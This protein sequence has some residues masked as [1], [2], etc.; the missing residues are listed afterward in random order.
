DL[1][2][3]RFTGKLLEFTG[4]LPAG[5]LERVDL[6]KNYFY[7]PANQGILQAFADRLGNVTMTIGGNCF[8][9]P[10]FFRLSEIPNLIFS[11][12]Q[13]DPSTC[14]DAIVNIRI[15]DSI[16]TTTTSTRPTTS[17]AILQQST[18]TPLPKLTAIPIQ[19]PTKFTKPPI[20]PPRETLTEIWKQA[21]IPGP[22]ATTISP[23]PTTT[24]ASQTSELGGDVIIGKRTFALIMVSILVVAFCVG[25]GVAVVI[26]RMRAERKDVQ[27][28]EEAEE[29]E[30]N[31]AG[32]EEE[33]PTSPRSIVPVS[34][35]RRTD[36]GRTA[37]AFMDE[38]GVTFTSFMLYDGAQAAEPR[39]S[40][41]TDIKEEDQDADVKEHPEKRGL[42]DRIEMDE[43][44]EP[45]MGLEL[46]DVVGR[47]RGAPRP[48]DEK[49]GGLEDSGNVVAMP[50][51][52][53]TPQV[54]LNPDVDNDP[55]KPVH[56]WTPDEVWIWLDSV[57]FREDVC[58][59]FRDH[60]VDGQR[61]LGLTDRILKHEMKIEPQSLRN[62]ILSIRGKSFLEGRNLSSSFL[63]GASGDGGGGS[64][65]GTSAGGGGV[66]QAMKG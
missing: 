50:P 30:G 7:G 21:N 4:G 22:T 66:F 48:R 49:A 33:E 12:P 32:D 3:N 1:S 65:A 27:E 24:I 59:K 51:V 26:G 62:A 46:P 41:S 37:D 18:F 5:K 44:T 6:L 17:T 15:P 39:S 36:S 8:R 25:V 60:E 38:Q 43:E 28:G 58:K 53:E 64:S 13:E 31:V 42:V 61:W 19:D 57:G 47:A 10:D 54:P 35:P 16:P 45:G 34:V 9:Q 2:K 63:P 11:Y 52:P 40:E 23:S 14:I 29:G 20:I 56:R 55:K